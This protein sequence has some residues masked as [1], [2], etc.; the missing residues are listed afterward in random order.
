MCPLWTL[1]LCPQD[2]AEHKGRRVYALPA[3]S[4]LCPLGVGR[5]QARAE[6]VVEHVTG[7]DGAGVRLR[8]LRGGGA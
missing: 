6:V 8:N 2:W 5:A 4:V 1:V 7:R 3:I